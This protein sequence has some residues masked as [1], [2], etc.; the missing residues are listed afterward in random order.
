MKLIIQFQKGQ[1]SPIK[2]EFKAI[3]SKVFKWDRYKE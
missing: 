3:F 1:Y 2:D